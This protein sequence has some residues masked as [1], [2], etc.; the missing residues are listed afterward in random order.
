MNIH[1]QQ[2]YEDFDQLTDKD[3]GLT[4]RTAAILVLAGGVYRVADRLSDLMDTL[5]AK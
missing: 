2:A 1:V 4:G 5:T 3:H